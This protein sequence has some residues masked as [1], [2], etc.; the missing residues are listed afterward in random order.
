MNPFDK[1]APLDMSL[2]KAVADAQP[3][4]AIEQFND[5][6]DEWKKAGATV[7]LKAWDEAFRHYEGAMPDEQTHFVAALQ[8]AFAMCQLPLVNPVSVPEIR[9]VDERGLGSN[10]DEYCYQ[11]SPDLVNR[12]LAFDV[13]V[14]LRYPDRRLEKGNEVRF[15][16]TAVKML[17]ADLK[18]SCL[19]ENQ[20]RQH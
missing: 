4:R 2:I 6:L 7:F 11:A 16:D 19:P 12:G 9:D 18:A 1:A 5:V 15:T 3:A 13:P 17:E 14:L 20:W 8:L 10:G